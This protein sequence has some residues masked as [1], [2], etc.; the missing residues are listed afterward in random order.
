MPKYRYFRE[1]EGCNRV[2]IGL[3]RGLQKGCIRVA[4]VASKVKKVAIAAL[5]VAMT[6]S[7]LQNLCPKYGV[8][9][10]KIKQ[11]P[12]HFY[13]AAFSVSIFRMGAFL[14]STFLGTH[15]I[16]CVHLKK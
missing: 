10:I 9:H 13:R 15:G 4:R 1:S 7:G 8:H 2:A 3:H 16:I 5:R 6:V 11:Y 14:L 12:S